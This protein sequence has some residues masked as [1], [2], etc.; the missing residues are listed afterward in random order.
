MTN[1]FNTQQCFYF[2][3]SILFAINLKAQTSIITDTSFVL[4]KDEGWWGGI[5]NRG[6]E[7]PFGKNTFSFD[8]YGEDDGNQASPFLVSSR[9]RY[10]WSNE[11]FAFAFKDGS[12][13]LNNIKGTVI[14]KQSGNTLQSAYLDASHKYFP[15]SGLWPDSLLITSPQYNLWIELQYNPNQKDV[16]NYAKQVVANRMPPRC[17]ND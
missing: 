5:V 4:L 15:S 6:A 13:F 17:I 12:V 2:L 8:L 7:M 11:P 1:R 10:I 3:L 9:G 16:L 14:V